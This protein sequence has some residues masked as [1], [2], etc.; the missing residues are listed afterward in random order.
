MDESDIHPVLQHEEKFDLLLLTL[1]RYRKIALAFSGGVDSTLL[2]YAALTA[3][4]AENVRAFYVRSNLNSATS[5]AECRMVFLKNFPQ[6]MALREIETAPLSWPEFAANDKNRCYYCKKR[7]YTLLLEV[8]KGAGYRTFAD[9]TNIDDVLDGRP[10]LRAVDELQVITPLAEV[11]LA[12][13]EVRSLAKEYNLSNHDLPSNS[14]LATRISHD[15]LLTEQKLR[16][17][18][19]AERFMH[20]QG[21]IGCR[22]KVQHLCTVV[23]VLEKDISVFV[24]PTNRAR[25]QSYFQSL[26]LA[27]VV[28]SLQGR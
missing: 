21:F 23:E 22:V 2:M 4:G 20:N 19:F 10:G 15:T 25:V 27:P 7:M 1:R 24:E 18:E 5:V 9:G 13:A 8:A 3:L 6:A 16:V 12:K 28:L 26:Q 17:I 14:C 11:G